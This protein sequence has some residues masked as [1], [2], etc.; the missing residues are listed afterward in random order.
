TVR[1]LLRSDMCRRHWLVR[2]IYGPRLR[3]RWRRRPPPALIIV[4]HVDVPTPAQRAELRELLEICPRRQSA[5][6]VMQLPGLSM[7]LGGFLDVWFPQMGRSGLFDLALVTHDPNSMHL[8]DVTCRSR[9]EAPVRAMG[10]ILG[11]RPP[12]AGTGKPPHEWK[13]NANQM[14]AERRDPV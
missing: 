13:K 8:T 2:Q 14:H 12:A 10:A 7:L 6:M 5:L 4:K 11:W 3:W 1:R 9:C